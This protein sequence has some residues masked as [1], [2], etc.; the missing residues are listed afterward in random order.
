MIGCL[1][2]NKMLCPALILALILLNLAKAVVALFDT[3]DVLYLSYPTL[4]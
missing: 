3:T 4:N 2:W 1:G